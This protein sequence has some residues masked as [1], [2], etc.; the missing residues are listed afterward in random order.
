[1]SSRR[2][3]S[4]SCK[5]NSFING[6]KELNKDVIEEL[7]TCGYCYWFAVVLKERFN[8][9]IIYNPIMNSVK[10]GW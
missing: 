6:F 3:S 2:E 4:T 9:V 8:G 1:M 5:I 7:F 10:I